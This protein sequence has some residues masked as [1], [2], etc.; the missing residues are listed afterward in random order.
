[1]YEVNRHMKELTDA[2]D[3]LKKA[4]DEKDVEALLIVK[5]C[6]NE[7]TKVDAVL[8]RCSQFEWVGIVDYVKDIIKSRY[9]EDDEPE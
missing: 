2:G 4:L 9:E 1:M 7:E 5:I 6:K 3:R 8:G